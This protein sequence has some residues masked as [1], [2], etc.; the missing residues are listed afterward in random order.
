MVWIIVIVVL[1]IGAIGIA[2]LANLPGEYQISRSRIYDLSPQ[3]LFDKIRDFRSWPQWSPWLIHE[4]GTHLEYSA[5]CDQ[6]GG[7]Y[8]WDGQYVGAGKLTHLRFQTPQR[9]EQEIE[10]TRPFKSVCQ[11]SFHFTERDEGTELTWSMQGRMPFLFRF[12][13]AKTVAMITKDYDLGLA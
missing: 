9:I 5:D 7:Y 12:M 10:F 3:Q 2:Y 4:P 1:V 8:S 13:T 11:V 6:E